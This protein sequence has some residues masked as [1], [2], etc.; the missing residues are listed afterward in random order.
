MTFEMIWSLDLTWVPYLILIERKKKY[1]DENWEENN[2]AN[3][4]NN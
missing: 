2:F 1:N 4:E 3:F